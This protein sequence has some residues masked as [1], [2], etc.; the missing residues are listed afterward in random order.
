MTA[1][2]ERP[3]KEV[4][5][6]KTQNK[7][8]GYQK[9][10]T[11]KNGPENTSTMYEVKGEIRAR[12]ISD[13]MWKQ[14]QGI[15]T[16]IP[17]DQPHLLLQVW[18]YAASRH[19]DIFSGHVYADTRRSYDQDVLRIMTTIS[20]YR[21][22]A[23]NSREFAGMD[24][25]V[26]GEM[27][28]LDFNGYILTGPSWV[29]V[30]VYR[31]TNGERYPVT[32]REWLIENIEVNNDGTP[33]PIWKKRPAGQLTVRAESQAFRKAFS[34]CE[35][36]TH[37]DGED[38]QELNHKIDMETGEVKYSLLENIISMYD[39]A[40]STEQV[41]RASAYVETHNGAFPQEKFTKII[42]AY[43]MASRR[44]SEIDNCIAIGIER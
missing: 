24:E 10:N 13:L 37:E 2:Q 1:T 22:V 28:T 19:L 26:F 4:A 33:G 3:T 44:V 11:P 34:D 18:D 23:H 40:S 21:S 7:A 16:K 32:A 15:F 43:E 36:V 25:P 17:N 14:L 5:F 12:N 35:P 29:Q 27:I 8:G 39:S 38:S 31:I 41:E 20:G 42:A 6:M 9:S 30:T